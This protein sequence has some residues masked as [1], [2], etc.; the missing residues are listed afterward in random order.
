MYGLRLMWRTFLETMKISARVSSL[1]THQW[2]AALRS[3]CALQAQIKCYKCQI[4]SRIIR[5][6]LWE[7]LMASILPQ[8]GRSGKYCA[9]CETNVYHMQ[10]PWYGVIAYVLNC[11]QVCPWLND[12]LEI[13][14]DG[15]IHKILAESRVFAALLRAPNKRPAVPAPQS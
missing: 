12:C 9:C 8:Y 3:L 14:I 15:D 2:W 10:S 6:C 11:N 13:N 4:N 7:Y 5:T 1:L